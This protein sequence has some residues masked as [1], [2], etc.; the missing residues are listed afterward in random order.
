MSGGGGGNAVGT[1]KGPIRTGVIGFGTSGRVFHAPFLST[2]PRYSLDVISTGH[3]DRAAEARALHPGVEVVP[4]ARAL[5]A[6]DLDLVV[7]G[8]PPASHVELATR[9]IEAGIAVV[10]DKPLAASAA[11]ARELLACARSRGV[12]LTVF[13]NRRWDGDFLTLRALLEQ[14]ALGEVRRFE[15]RFEWF[16]PVETKEW[17]ARASAE[18]GGG[19]LLDLGT[20]LLDQA[21]LLFGEVDEVHAETARRREGAG[22]EDD[23]FVALRHRGGVLS[24]LWM[25]AVAPLPG[26]RFHVLGSE[27][28]F[29]SSG[30]DPQ[31]AALKAGALPTDE[32]FGV[33]GSSAVL[34]AGAAVEEQPLLPGR[35]AAFYSGLADALL[36]G[37]PLPVDPE[38]AVRV[39]DLIERIRAAAR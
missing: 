8:S 15:S 36:D 19:I 25:S 33:A 37:A 11:E 30:L 38:D 21:L 27:A 23:V 2:S 28:G 1:E 5:L 16:K 14:G 29:T 6:R 4:D 13:Q 17:K 18:Q 26:P 20:H 7:I 3:A 39:L 24:H 12:P 35:Y 10:V 31:E 34:G 9:A 32:G 22:A